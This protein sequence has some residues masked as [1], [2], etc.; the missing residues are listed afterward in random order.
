MFYVK[1]PGQFCCVGHG[2]LEKLRHGLLVWIP[3]EVALLLACS[4]RLLPL[5]A[6][7]EQLNTFLIL[8]LKS[9]LRHVQLIIDILLSG[10]D[11]FAT[12]NLSELWL[13]AHVLKVLLVL[14]SLDFDVIAVKPAEN[15]S[16][17]LFHF[18][19]IYN[20]VG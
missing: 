19:L 13:F 7:I 8:L 2:V 6:L 9:I 5:H 1:L 16:N 3:G 20:C 12:F 15:F 17:L 10:L 14:G 11:H 4:L 18:D